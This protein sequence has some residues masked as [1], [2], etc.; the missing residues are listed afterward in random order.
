MADEKEAFERYKQL[1]RKEGI[2]ALNDIEDAHKRELED[3][4]DGISAIV[5]NAREKVDAVY[6]ESS[7]PE[8][9]SELI[10][11]IEA[12]ADGDAPG[13][14]FEEGISGVEVYE[15]WGL[16]KGACADSLRRVMPDLLRWDAENR[17]KWVGYWKLV[18]EH[19]KKIEALKN[20]L[21]TIRSVRSA[22]IWNDHRSKDE[23]RRLRGIAEEHTDELK[24]VRDYLDRCPKQGWPKN[25][26]RLFESV[27]PDEKPRN[28]HQRFHNWWER[29]RD[30]DFPSTVGRLHQE[31]EQALQ[32]RE[33]FLLSQQDS[34][35]SN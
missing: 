13:L 31:C 32:L 15:K 7:L 35:Q 14:Y 11:W 26:T 2:G 23:R 4:R 6:S 29:D 25:R 21:S 34:Q 1:V 9:R 30:L 17:K 33:E 8:Q 18:Y 12:G 22:V 24:D 28:V 27:F 19:R 16:E 3:H 5:E 10:E 20:R